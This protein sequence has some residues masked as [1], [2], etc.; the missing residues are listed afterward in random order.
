LNPFARHGFDIVF[1]RFHPRGPSCNLPRIHT[2]G[3]HDEFSQRYAVRGKPAAFFSI[4]GS[5]GIGILDR[6]DGGRFKLRRCRLCG[7]CCRRCRCLTEDGGN[8][9]RSN[10]EKKPGAGIGAIAIKLRSMFLPFS[11]F[12][13]R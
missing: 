3:H 10:G 11:G 8:Q 13:V 1:V 9:E 5:A 6:L 4:A 12:A 7:R 2:I